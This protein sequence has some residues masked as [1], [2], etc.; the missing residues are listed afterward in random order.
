MGASSSISNC[1]YISSSEND[2]WAANICQNLKDNGCNA[3]QYDINNFDISTSSAS[4]ESMI[5]KSICIIVCINEKSLRSFHQMIEINNILD[6][7]KKIIYVMTDSNFTPLTLIHLNGF[8]KNNL[9][10]N[11]YDEESLEYTLSKI[12]EIL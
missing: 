9:W 11:A 7:N 10:M 5:S 8:I 1:I 12:K 3:I 6:S 4:I 2:R